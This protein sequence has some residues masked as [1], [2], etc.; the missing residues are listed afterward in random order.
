[1]IKRSDL[2]AGG[3][4]FEIS[5][6]L[7]GM[8]FIRFPIAV[9]APEGSIGFVNNSQRQTGAFFRDGKWSDIRNKPLKWEPTHWTVMLTKDNADG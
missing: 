2:P 8:R 9:A 3:I 4:E 1:M 7:A 6:V 5:G